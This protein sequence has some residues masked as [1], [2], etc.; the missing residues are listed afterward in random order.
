[1][2]KMGF[3]NR[4]FK[5]HEEELKEVI[6]VEAFRDYRANNKFRYKVRTKGSD[7]TTY[8]GMLLA[9]AP[10]PEIGQMINPKEWTSV[11]PSATYKEDWRNM[12]GL[13]SISEAHE[14]PKIAEICIDT[15]YDMYMI[16]LG[17]GLF[18]TLPNLSDDAK[19]S[20]Y[21]FDLLEETDF[22]GTVIIPTVSTSTIVPLGETLV[23]PEALETCK[24]YVS[25][26]GDGLT[27]LNL[28][29]RF[30]QEQRT[31]AAKRI[32]EM[33]AFNQLYDRK[34]L[35]EAKQ[36]AETHCNTNSLEERFE[37]AKRESEETRRFITK[38]HGP[39]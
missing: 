9:R 26:S 25:F 37:S 4:L 12:Y 11:D 16:H 32:D 18:L 24:K 38:R 34:P 23:T 35:E 5:K 8:S 39:R 29:I 31:D 2:S 3:L 20:L 28:A 19:A 22:E 30:L 7:G 1:M 6:A 10:F 14:M 13:K 15:H 21:N 36:R 27:A 33:V 17:V